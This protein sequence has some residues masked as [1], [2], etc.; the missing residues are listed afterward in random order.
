MLS[1]GSIDSEKI[2][3]IWSYTQV[4]G[5]VTT[6]GLYTIITWTSNGSFTVNSGKRNTDIL[7][8]GAGGGGAG[9][10][11]GGYYNNYQLQTLGYDS[12]SGGG[13]GGVSYTSG[14]LL[15][16]SSGQQNVTI[17]AGGS[18][19]YIYINN[20]NINN[21][22]Y[23]ANGG[24]SSFGSI[25]QNGGYCG[26]SGGWSASGQSGG[27]SGN[28]YAGGSGA[29][30]YAG[31]GGGSNGNGLT[32]TLST[33]APFY[34]GVG[35]SSDISGSTQIYGYGGT[36]ETTTFNFYGANTAGY[37]DG[38]FGGYISNLAAQGTYSSY[39]SQGGYGH[40]GVVII[41][42]LT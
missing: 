29:G 28:G 39:L 11:Y 27:A 34:G 30:V 36:L 23:A 25:S 21:I 8:V 26:G 37:G 35:T 42:F 40:Q 5:T 41:R 31:G 7:V 4:G 24:S 13:A 19:G 1:I 17:G 20:Y 18:Y 10:G 2:G 33:P 38:G 6:S 14:K 15:N 9:G 22:I 32:S 3:N 16:S 12:G